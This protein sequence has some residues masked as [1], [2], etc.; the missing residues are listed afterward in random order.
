MHLPRNNKFFCLLKACK[1]DIGLAEVARLLHTISVG[2]ASLL[3]HLSLEEMAD[4]ICE[5]LKDAL[6]CF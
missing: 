6:A 2:S 1:D 4:E 3:Q 5:S